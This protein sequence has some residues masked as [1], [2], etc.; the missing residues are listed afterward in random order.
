MFRCLSHNR[1]GALALVALLSTAGSVVQ[2][3]PIKYRAV[4]ITNSTSRPI[5]FMLNGLSNEWQVLHPGQ[6]KTWKSEFVTGPARVTV[7]FCRDVRD[8]ANSHLLD[9]GMTTVFLD[10]RVGASGSIA[11]RF[12]FRQSGYR[13]SLHRMP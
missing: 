12:Q 8:A 9:K 5:H 2:A 10:S 1:L 3:G 6:T 4:S 11:N 7:R 13:L